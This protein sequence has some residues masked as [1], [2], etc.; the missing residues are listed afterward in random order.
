MVDDMVNALKGK[1]SAGVFDAVM[2]PETLI[3]SAEIADRLGG[4][5]SVG[6]ILPPMAHFSFPEG[7]PEGVKMHWCKS[8]LT[9]RLANEPNVG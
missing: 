4:N 1:D 3:K 5:K 8:S 2:P 6:T 7:L 9:I